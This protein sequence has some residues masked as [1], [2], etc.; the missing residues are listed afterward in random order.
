VALLD[1]FGLAFHLSGALV[2]VALAWRF[3]TVLGPVLRDP[4]EDDEGGGS[5]RAPHTPWT[6]RPR[7]RPGPSDRARRPA[8]P[9]GPRRGSPALRGR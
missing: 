2:V 9:R 5:D 6:W 1:L 8:G 3:R 4:G 7:G